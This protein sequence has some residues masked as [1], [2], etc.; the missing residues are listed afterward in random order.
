MTYKKGYAKEFTV[1]E[2]I[3]F[4]SKFS[5]A[6]GKEKCCKADFFISGCS[7]LLPAFC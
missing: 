7:V 3:K 4:A 5:S 1:P 2:A 6:Y